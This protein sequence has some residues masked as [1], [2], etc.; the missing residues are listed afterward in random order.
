M[1]TKQSSIEWL[2][3]RIKLGDKSFDEF[4]YGYI[5]E[6]KEMHKKEIIK[7]YYGESYSTSIFNGEDYYNKTFGK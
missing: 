3:S 7:A 4:F 2:V 5:E 1:E 6:A